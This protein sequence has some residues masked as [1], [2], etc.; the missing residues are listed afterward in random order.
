MWALHPS[1]ALSLLR[2]RAVAEQ[3][4]AEARQQAVAAIAAIQTAAAR[5]VMADLM[6]GDDKLLA[7]SANELVNAR[8]AKPQTS[9]PI[10]SAVTVATPAPTAD[11]PNPATMSPR[12]LLASKYG[13]YAER[14][15]AVLELAQT[16][17]G[18]RQLIDLVAENRL[19]NAMLR[20]AGPALLKHPSVAIRQQAAPYF[21][22]KQATT[23]VAADSTKVTE[24][25]TTIVTPPAKP[26]TAPESVAV[27]IRKPI[28]SVPDSNRTTTTA[29][30]A[31]SSGAPTKPEVAEIAV[32]TGNATTGQLV[33]KSS[34]S[35]CH[36]YN[37]KGVDVGPELTNVRQQLD[38]NGLI[39]SIVYPNASITPG[40]EPWLVTTTTGQSYYGFINS[41]TAQSVVVKGVTGQKH[42]L[43]INT[44]SSRRKF[45]NS[46]MPSAQ[47]MKLS[48]QQIADITAYLLK[49]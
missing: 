8:K 16:A 18:A 45:T 25:K 33:F 29:P 17:E 41:E 30:A 32:L 11:K 40:Y 37:Q 20:I 42:T 9:A 47:T 3:L 23:T 27:A 21:E 43:P 38:K 4:P 13:T 1:S 10:T 36:V 46:L 34:C 15:K 44:V 49:M 48:Q 5:N 7:A 14:S 28:A 22:P 39:E 31:V 6:R 35:R 12:D 2:K 26:V 19:S 24:P